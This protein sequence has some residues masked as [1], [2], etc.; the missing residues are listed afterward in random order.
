MHESR[1]DAEVQDGGLREALA[2]LKGAATRWCAEY[3][4]VHYISARKVARPTMPPQP[5]F[6]PRKEPPGIVWPTGSVG[7][8]APLPPKQPRSADDVETSFWAR[9]FGRVARLLH[10]RRNGD[11]EE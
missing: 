4:Q 8:K 11:A 7:A 3:K 9:F 5:Q 6:E 1:S 10:A 2:A